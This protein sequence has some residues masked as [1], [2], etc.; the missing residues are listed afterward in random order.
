MANWHSPKSYSD[1]YLHI[2]CIRTLIFFTLTNIFQFLP[3]FSDNFG[4]SLLIPFAQL[5]ARLRT[6]SHLGVFICISSPRNWLL[7]ILPIFLLALK[8]KNVSI[9]VLY[10]LWILF[11]WCICC[12]YIF[13]SVVRLLSVYG[14]LCCRGFKIWCRQNYWSFPH[15]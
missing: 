15:L 11:D 2:Q 9:G 4:I 3:I 6:F 13:Q 7:E 12:K 8:K 5:L 10:I 1:L 14:V